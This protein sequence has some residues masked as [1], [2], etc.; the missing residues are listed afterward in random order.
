MI[1]REACLLQIKTFLRDVYD[2]IVFRDIVQ[3]GKIKD[4]DL[5][6]RIRNTASSISS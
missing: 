6:G 2:A 5:F 3:C 4:I 1:I